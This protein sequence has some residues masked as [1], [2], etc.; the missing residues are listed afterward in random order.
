MRPILGAGKGNNAYYASQYGIGEILQAGKAVH[1]SYLDLLVSYG[2]VGFA[3][4][5][6]F[7]VYC[8]WNVLKNISKHKKQMGLVYYADVLIVFIVACSSMFL[9]SIFIATTAMYY[10]MLVAVG[11]LMSFHN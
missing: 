9:T 3:V 4:M 6:S 11:Y 2:A 7:W 8:F 1:N 10:V 5:M